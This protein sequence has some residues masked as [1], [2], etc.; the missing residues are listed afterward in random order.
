[1]TAILVLEN[2]R[3]DEACH[4][5]RRKECNCICEGAFHGIGYNAAVSK[6]ADEMDEWAEEFEVNIDPPTRVEVKLLDLLR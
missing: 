2:H 1:M 3:C 6:L 4:S 5:A